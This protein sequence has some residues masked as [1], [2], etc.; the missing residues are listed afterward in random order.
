MHTRLRFQAIRVITRAMSD[1]PKENPLHFGHPGRVQLTTSERR[2]RNKQRRREKK[3]ELKIAYL[4]QLDPPT[5]FIH[6]GLYIKKKMYWIIIIMWNL[7]QRETLC[8]S[9]LSYISMLYKTPMGW[10]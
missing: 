3:L 7:D 1:I 9:I 2:N 5:T 6:A 4:D 10:A 8:S